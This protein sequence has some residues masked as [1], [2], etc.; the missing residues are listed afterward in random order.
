VRRA[1]HAGKPLV[2]R[3]RTAR[4][5]HHGG[6]AGQRT[7]SRQRLRDVHG[8]DDDQAKWWVERLEKD[9]A[10]VLLDGGRLVA[11]GGEPRGVEQGGGDVIGHCAVRAR[12][13]LRPVRESRHQAPRA[14]GERVGT[15]LLEQRSFHS[16]SSTNT[17]TCPPQASPTSHAISLVTPNSRRRG[18]PSLITA[19]ASRITA[20]SMQPPDTEPTNAPSSLTASWL[21]AGRG[22]EPQA[23]TTVASAT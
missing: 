8:A 6:E 2:R 17:C 1:F 3:K 19:I 7:H 12:K 13:P 23:R 4:V 10:A 16:I 20:P 9:R 15:Q 5:D 11:C 18:M 14:L 21:P 22:D